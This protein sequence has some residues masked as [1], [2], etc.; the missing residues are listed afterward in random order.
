MC[1]AISLHGHHHYF[2]RNLD[3]EVALEGSLKLKGISYIHSEAYAAGELKHGTISL[4]TEKTPVI[5]LFGDRE[6][7]PKTLSNLKEVASR[8]AKTIAISAPDK[9]IA[10]VSDIMLDMPRSGELRL[11]TQSESCYKRFRL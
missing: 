7:I 11:L 1:T 10:E 6:M 5:A 3:Y 4:I 2:G 9:D 8:G